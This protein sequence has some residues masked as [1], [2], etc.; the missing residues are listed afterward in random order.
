MTIKELVKKEPQGMIAKAYKFAETAHAKQKRKTGE[1]YFIHVLAT[2]EILN[3]WHLDEA[4]IDGGLLHDTVEDTG[5]KIEDIAKEFGEQVAFLVAGVTKLGKIK[6]RGSEA[7]AKAENLRKMILA[8]SE[9]LRVVFIKL[10]DRLHNMRT[11]SALPPQKQK[12]I[13]LETHEI[14]APLAIRLGMQ[15]LSGELHDLAF[16]YLYPEEYKWLDAQ[17]AEAYEARIKYLEKL[18]PVVKKTLEE[19]GILPQTIDFRAKR[20][21]S[22]YVKLLRRNMD[23]ENIYDLVAMRVIVRTTEDCYAALGIIHNLWPPIP[24]RIK[25]YIAMPKPNGYRSLHTTVI[26]PDKKLVEFQIRTEEMHDV[27]EHGIAAHWIYKTHGGMSPD[28]Q[29]KVLEGAKWLEQLR[30]WQERQ[31][32]TGASPDDF[33][34]SLKVDFFKDRIFVITPRGEVI[35]LPVGSTPVDFAYHIHTQIGDAC[36]GAK[37]NNQIVPL[38]HELR[39]GDFV[40]ILAQKNKKPSE[41]WLT[42]VKTSLARDH[43]RQALRKKQGALRR[44]APM[45][46]ELKI[47]AEDRVGL[48]KDVAIIVARSHINIESLTTTNAPIGNFQIIKAICNT[49]EK[50]KIERLI[51]KLKAIKEIKEISYRLLAPQAA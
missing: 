10:A 50:P 28:K 16:P 27:A 39:S 18:K 31:A 25:D 6:Y 12:R 36:F 13:A 35:D 8:I 5:V 41:D 2:A 38:N 34:E 3:S 29:K 47:T 17:V 22:L 48:I 51:L 40:E 20:Y 37:V 15:N 24:G 30:R 14:Y 21:N 42:F 44:S 9:D 46:T 23:V 7:E 33:L 11:L 45:K 1:P 49:V 4:T 26:G 43:I 32:E 19:K